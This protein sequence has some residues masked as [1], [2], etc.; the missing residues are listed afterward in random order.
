MRERADRRL[1]AERGSPMRQPYAFHPIVGDELEP[2]VALSHVPLGAPPLI[3][4]LDV[5]PPQHKLVLNGTVRGAY[6]VLPV[7]SPVAGTVY[8]LDGQGSVKPLGSVLGRGVVRVE[9]PPAALLLGG[10]TFT[11]QTRTGTVTVSLKQ[12]PPPTA[13]VPIPGRSYFRFTITGGTGAF[14]GAT[15]AGRAM[16]QLQPPTGLSGTF[17]L[18][19]HSS[20]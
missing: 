11:L 8:G 10:G 16:L 1:S 17:S 14:R 3:A 7:L 19:L 5:V 12:S 20:A 6:R 13:G 9:T 15:G 2:R 18:S 4:P